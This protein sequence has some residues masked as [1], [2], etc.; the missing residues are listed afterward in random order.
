MG[1]FLLEAVK[2]IGSL[3]GICAAAFLLWDRYTKHFPVALIVP[4]PIMPGSRNI[5]HFLYVKNASDRPVLIF[6]EL[7]D[8]TRLRVAKDH[9]IEGIAMTLVGGESV[10]S[11]VQGADVFLPIL[12]PSNY[13][14]IDPDNILEIHLR[15]RF[16]QPRIWKV[17]RT[18]PVSIRKRD[19]DS[20]VDEYIAPSEGLSA[21]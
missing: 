17:D 15:W 4:R 1:E 7:D 14:D 18:I 2:T 21:G 13:A 16:A 10:I 8:S 5:S 6:W 11:L 20:M 9:S 12:R 19:F 3:S